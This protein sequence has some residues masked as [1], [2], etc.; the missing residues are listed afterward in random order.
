MSNDRK[1]CCCYCGASPQPPVHHCRKF[2]VPTSEVESTEDEA[3]QY[4]SADLAVCVSLTVT[5]RWWILPHGRVVVSI[6]TLLEC[7]CVH[8]A[9]TTLRISK[10]TKKCGGR[11]W[12]LPRSPDRSRSSFRAGPSM[13]SCRYCSLSC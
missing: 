11:P 7:L 9:G 8:R 10:L 13:R 12:C 6:V 2:E 4:P 3:A 1:R 5:A